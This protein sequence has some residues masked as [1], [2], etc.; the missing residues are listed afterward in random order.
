MPMR[1]EMNDA[2]GK[3]TLFG[4]GCHRSMCCEVMLERLRDAHVRRSWKNG[5]LVMLGLKVVP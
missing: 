2:S 4:R 1:G 5:A 3:S